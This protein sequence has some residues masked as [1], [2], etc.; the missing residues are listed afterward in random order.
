MAN[1]GKSLKI[2]IK[3]YDVYMMGLIAFNDNLFDLSYELLMAGMDL[4]LERGEDDLVKQIK[5]KLI[6]YKMN[7]LLHCQFRIE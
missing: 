3:T 5:T 1:Y 2:L 4:G 6:G 7:T